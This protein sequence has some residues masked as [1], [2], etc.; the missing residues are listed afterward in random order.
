MKGQ[1]Y[2]IEWL[3]DPLKGHKDIELTIDIPNEL[4]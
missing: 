4:N 3:E 1:T 2:T